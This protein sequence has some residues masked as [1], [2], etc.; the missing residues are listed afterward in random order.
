MAGALGLLL[1]GEEQ[2]KAEYDLSERLD[3]D[4]SGTGRSLRVAHAA[5]FRDAKTSRN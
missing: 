4:T 2:G 3:G 5:R 1:T